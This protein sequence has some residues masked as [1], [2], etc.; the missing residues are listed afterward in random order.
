[1]T[2]APGANAFAFPSARSEK[3]TP[4]ASSRSQRCMAMFAACVPCMPSMPRLMG[5]SGS[6]LPSPIR[7][8]AIGASMRAERAFSSSAA[9]VTP[10]PA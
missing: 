6:L 5:F 4:T 8:L 3:R 9:S 7:V 2:R 1:M 10:P